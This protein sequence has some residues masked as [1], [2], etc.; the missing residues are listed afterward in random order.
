M[1]VRDKQ[2]GKIIQK[3]FNIFIMI[4]LSAMVLMVFTNAVLRY[5]FNKS[6]PETEE[7]AR[8]CFIWTI[9]LGIIAAYKDGEHVAVSLLVDNLK[10]IPK[11]TVQI[12]ARVITF[13]ALA[14]ILSGGIIYTKHA[15]TYVTAATGTNFAFISIAIVIMAAGM[16]LLDLRK[17]YNLLRSKLKKAEE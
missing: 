16:I 10:G 13:F 11:K 5:F 2:D 17:L 9:F 6:L 4:A 14:F 15:S 1:C 8:F 3:L 7:F 12:I